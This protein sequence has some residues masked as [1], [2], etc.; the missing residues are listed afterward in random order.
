MSNYFQGRKI[1]DLSKDHDQFFDKIQEIKEEEKQQDSS[2]WSRNK[3]GKNIG[4]TKKPHIW[5][6][7]TRTL[8]A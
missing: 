2:W 8:D 6:D 1:S 3:P 5:L 7:G 4:A